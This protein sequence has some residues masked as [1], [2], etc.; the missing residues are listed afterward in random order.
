MPSPCQEGN[1]L[2]SDG[3]VVHG[4]PRSAVRL[5]Q[6]GQGRGCRKTSRGCETLRTERAGGWNL[7]ESS[8]SRDTGER[9]HPL[10]SSAE[11]DG[12]SGEEHFLAQG[13]AV[14]GR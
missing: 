11:G 7:R 9:G 1:F 5:K 4:N 13:S 12:T 14:D 6:T 3:E 2:T 8:V 10:L